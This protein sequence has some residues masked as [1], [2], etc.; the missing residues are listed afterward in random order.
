ME[1]SVAGHFALT[2]NV[3]GP[4]EMNETA[5]DCVGALI[6]YCGLTLLL[7]KREIIG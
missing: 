5:S 7:L 2:P 1:T 4:L 3:Q 6:S